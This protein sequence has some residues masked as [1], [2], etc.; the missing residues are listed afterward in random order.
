MTGFINRLLHFCCTSDLCF[1]KLQK[2]NISKHIQNFVLFNKI[3]RVMFSSVHL[4]TVD[5]G[6]LFNDFD[7]N[8]IFTF[9]ICVQKQKKWDQQQHVLKSLSWQTLRTE[10]KTIVTFYTLKWDWNSQTLSLTTRQ[11]FVLPSWK[12]LR[13]VILP[14]RQTTIDN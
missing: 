1:I 3:F 11:G 6:G 12:V 5:E 13:G 14:A 9:Q 8:M 2:Q 4:C 7:R 10:G